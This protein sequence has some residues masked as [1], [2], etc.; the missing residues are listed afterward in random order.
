MTIALRL[1]IDL[2]I[3]LIG[4]PWNDVLKWAHQYGVIDIIPSIFLIRPT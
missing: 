1:V 3:S 2:H 4:I